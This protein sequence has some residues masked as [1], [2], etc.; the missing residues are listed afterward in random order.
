M[1]SSKEIALLILMI[2]VMYPIAWGV[3]FG[4]LYAGKTLAEWGL[5]G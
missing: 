5:L 4:V 2:I 1:G 3:I